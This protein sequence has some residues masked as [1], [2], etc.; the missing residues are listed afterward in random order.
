MQERMENVM[1]RWI[2]YMPLASLVSGLGVLFVGERALHDT[3][4][5][6]VSGLGAML[7]LAGMALAIVRMGMAH[8]DKQKATK[9]ILFEYAIC[10]FALLLYGLQMSEVNLVPQG[11]VQVMLM[12]AWPGVLC[13]GLLPLVAMEL[14]LFGMAKSIRMESW[15]LIFAGRGA[16]VVALAL[17]IFAGFNY[18]AV[19]WNRKI[20]LSYFKTTKPGTSTIAM[21]QHLTKP[22]RVVL[23]FNPGNEVLEQA[24]TYLNHLARYNEHIQVQITDQAVDPKMA[25]ELK[26]SNNG[27]MALLYDNQKEV[28]RLGRDLETSRHILR[29]LDSKVQ[30]RLFKILRPGRTVYFT[31]GH[32]ERSAKMPED[33]DRLAYHDFESMLK[34]LGLRVEQLG[35]AEGLGSKIPEDAS[36]VIVAGP[37]ETFLPEERRTLD[38]YLK[39]GGRML[40]LMDPDHGVTENEL[41]SFVGLEVTDAL[42]AHDRY[43]VRV[44]GQSESPY[45]LVTNRP[46]NH[47]T[48]QTLANVRGKM[49]TVL[50]GTGAVEKAASPP[51]GVD[52]NYILHAMQNSWLDTNSNGKFDEKQEKREQ[53]YFAMA[54]ER[55]W[56]P[57]KTSKLSMRAVVVG[58]ADIAGDGLM[59]N[60]GN[61][62]F[63]RDTVFWLLGDD[64]AQG[65]VESEKDVP[66]VHRKDEDAIW[67]YGTSLLIPIA[68]L[69][70]GLTVM[71]PS[72]R[73]RRED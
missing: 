12:V 65:T 68:V 9:R 39:R 38:A 56:E 70:L 23:F 19:R 44:Q 15:R 5:I 50:I 14:A 55:N 69:T 2:L 43:L 40:F 64:E 25:Q 4:R 54:A 53:L 67:F 24:R 59:G 11:R 52:F 72:R 57:G 28:I 1:P 33:D 63:L 34:K 27:F 60:P 36:L 20:D 41:L 16:R 26:V 22:L 48:V 10:V 13:L 6:V 62:Y 30:E 8:G 29:E 46:G 17:I 71:Y 49:A 61:A 42:V 66:I 58:D 35:L 21:V 3:A 51:P 31:T 7:F 47:P 37:L 73:S 32:L 18:S 45:H